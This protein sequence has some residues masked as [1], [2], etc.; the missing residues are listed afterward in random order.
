MGY[1]KLVHNFRLAFDP[2]YPNRDHSNFQDC[3]WIDFYKGA[4][5]VIPPVAPLARGKQ[6]E[7]HVANNYADNKSRRSRTGF[8]IHMITSLINWYSKKQSSMKKSVFYTEFAAMK[9]GVEMWHAILH[10]VRMICVPISGPSYNYGDKM[11][12]IHNT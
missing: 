3:D 10:E 4:V 7:L 8:M 6:V 5:E 1:L 12:I 2:S 9:L 11:S